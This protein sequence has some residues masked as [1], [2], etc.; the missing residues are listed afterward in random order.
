[1]RIMLK[2]VNDMHPN[3]AM[4]SMLLISTT[5][6]FILFQLALWIPTTISSIVP[7][8]SK[9]LQFRGG[10]ESATKDMIIPIRYLHA[11]DR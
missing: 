8:I 9:S 6:F 5:I 7:D 11:C 2:K 3:K 10:I 1:M 4:T